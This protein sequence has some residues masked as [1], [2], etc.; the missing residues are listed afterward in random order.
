MDYSQRI[1]DVRPRQDVN[2]VLVDLHIA[3]GLA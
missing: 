3:D 1:D 2:I